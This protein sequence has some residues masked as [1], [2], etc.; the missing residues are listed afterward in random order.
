MQQL[1]I[2]SEPVVS[3]LQVFLNGN[4]LIFAQDNLLKIVKS[5]SLTFPFNAFHVLRRS[6]TSKKSD[7]I[8]IKM[9]AKNAR[10]KNHIP[11]HW[12]AVKVSRSVAG[13][14]DC[15]AMT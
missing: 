2:S 12:L 1:H 6:V 13:F 4:F 3:Y 9:T 15:T 8:S 10:E 11:L 5:A 7:S 14:K